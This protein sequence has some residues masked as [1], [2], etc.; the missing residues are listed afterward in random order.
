MLN[1]A[2]MKTPPSWSVVS[3]SYKGSVIKAGLFNFSVLLCVQWLNISYS[4]LNN[5]AI[6][7]QLTLIH[8]SFMQCSCHHQVDHGP[9]LDSHLKSLSW[10]VLLIRKTPEM[11]AEGLPCAVCYHR[12][13]QR[14]F[15]AKE[16]LLFLRCP[17]PP[18]GCLLRFHSS[19]GLRREVHLEAETPL[20]SKVSAFCDTFQEAPKLAVVRSDRFPQY[21][22]A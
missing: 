10:L 20:H 14:C 3:A 6:L 2:K 8:V 19:E 1:S 15:P 5:E 13:A 17:V 4:A 18:P 11:S 16:L 22:P 12:S 9:N 21:H 7:F